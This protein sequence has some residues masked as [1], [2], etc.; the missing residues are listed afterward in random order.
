MPRGPTSLAAL[1]APKASSSHKAHAPR[2][3]A[4]ASRTGKERPASLKRLRSFRTAAAATG[5]LE[6]QALCRLHR[7]E[8]P[9]GP[10][11][12]LRARQ[13]GVTARLGG[14]DWPPKTHR[15][16]GSNGM[17]TKKKEQHNSSVQ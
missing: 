5:L 6:D 12:P 4:V 2:V 16:G 3:R 17:N 15:W 7:W 8:L 9:Q 10:A 11:L 13:A 1:P 14:E